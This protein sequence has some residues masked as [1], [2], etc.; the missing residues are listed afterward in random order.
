MDMN[1]FQSDLQAMMQNYKVHPMILVFSDKR[2]KVFFA[3]VG[4]PSIEWISR[5]AASLM[6]RL[7]ENVNHKMMIEGM[8]S[9]LGL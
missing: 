1:K 6:Q 3:T 8:G 4:N 7:E 9:K 2:G 5:S